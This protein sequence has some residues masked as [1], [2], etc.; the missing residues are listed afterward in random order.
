MIAAPKFGQWLEVLRGKRT[1]E[2]VARQIRPLVKPVGL[3]VDQS[4]IYKIEK[5]RVPSWPLLGAL[6]R[7][8]K[9][10]IRRAVLQLIETLEFPGSRDLLRPADGAEL[11]LPAPEAA[12]HADPVP[13][14]EVQAAVRSILREVLTSAIGITITREGADPDESLPGAGAHET[15]GGRADPT[16]RGA[17]GRL[18]KP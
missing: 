17:A 2:Q 13:R 15:Q 12:P 4:Q 18:G 6:C 11:A 3:K 16:R 8:Y 9:V 1:L 7:V 14:A 5:G 10:D